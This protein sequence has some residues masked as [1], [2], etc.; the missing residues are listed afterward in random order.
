MTLRSDADIHRPDHTEEAALSF[1]SL[2]LLWQSR[3]WS[4]A[5]HS[6]PGDV[7][8]QVKPH[9]LKSLREMLGSLMSGSVR[10]TITALKGTL[11]WME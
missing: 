5:D 11:G 4:V 2:A 7:V 9:V 6:P 10:G 8:R 1:C 3:V